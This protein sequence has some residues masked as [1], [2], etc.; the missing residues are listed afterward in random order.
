MAVGI[1]NAAKKRWESLV[2][3]A[4][5]PNGRP[6]LPAGARLGP[7]TI[8]GRA[9]TR[10]AALLQQGRGNNNMGLAG[11]FN[12]NTPTWAPPNAPRAPLNTKKFITILKSKVKAKPPAVPPVTP[13]T[14]Q[15][16][17]KLVTILK[18]KAVTGK[19]PVNTPEAAALLEA[20]TKKNVQNTTV[21]RLISILKSKIKPPTFTQSNNSHGVIKNEKGRVIGSVF[22]NQNGNP[23]FKVKGVFKT[24]HNGWSL[25][26]VG[27]T[28]YRLVYTAPEKAASS[29]NSKGSLIRILKNLA[30]RMPKVGA[31]PPKP[32]EVLNQFEEIVENERNRV[33]EEIAASKARGL[34]TR[35]QLLMREAQLANAA[36]KLKAAQENSTPNNVS[37]AAAAVAAAVPE[38]R[39]VITATITHFNNRQPV[40][41]APLNWGRV[42]GSPVPRAAQ[43]QRPRQA[44]AQQT[45][46]P[47]LAQ[48]AAAQVNAAEQAPR[49][50]AA[51]RNQRRNNAMNISPEFKKLMEQV[52]AAT[53]AA[54]AAPNNSAKFEALQQAIKE[55]KNHP[56]SSELTVR[57]LDI[58]ERM[59]GNK[60]K[61]PP[62]PK[63]KEAVAQ[64]TQ[65]LK[66]NITDLEKKEEK[67]EEKAK[68]T[69]LANL[70]LNQLLVYRRNAKN[71]KVNVNKQIRDRLRQLLSNIRTGPETNR[72]RKYNEILKYL[73]KNYVGRSDIATLLLD[74]VRRVGGHNSPRVAL[75]RLSNL[76]NNIG[77]F[78]NAKV[79]EAFEKQVKRAQAN[80][81]RRRG[82]YREN[83]GG[84]RGNRGEYYSRGNGGGYR[85]NGGGYYPPRGNG[86]GYPPARGNGGGY[87]PARG[88]G[89]VPLNAGINTLPNNQKRALEAVP[90]G[91]T[92]ANAV[93]NSVPGGQKAV[94]EAAE[95]L[96]EFPNAKQAME[97]KGISPTAIAAVKKIAGNKP[98]NA[99][100]IVGAV[101]TL[102]KKA[103]KTSSGVKRRRKPTGPRTAEI[104]RVLSRTLKKNLASLV[105][106]N[107][108]KTNNIKGT[109]KKYKKP[110]LK[111]LTKAQILRT[112]AANRARQSAKKQKNKS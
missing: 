2:R 5:G 7:T 3:F 108:T 65:N 33:A 82:E 72:A 36:N 20:A 111:I 104:N 105:A 50:R 4:P 18:S 89:G 11:L 22:L 41:G 99:I 73:P 9:A 83:R 88:N 106:H 90:G 30:A 94:I 23:G 53:T 76:R 95:A 79:V 59:Y 8:R 16:V 100:S 26:K 71:N 81:G 64:T 10:R 39:P 60:N 110:A 42:Q 34:P 48:N 97:V 25:N 84:Y 102:K 24:E 37:R 47:P 56:P 17:N 91:A 57:L 58:F 98:L 68:K 38:A 29:V 15:I 69:T 43:Q 87:P 107:I 27:N 75:Q 63:V 35:R 66:N 52:L 40:T 46:T 85:G 49:Q 21:T 1:S 96:N 14:K 31:P 44:A 55:L 62:T 74:E 103:R 112:K 28:E 78:A 70:S 6:N 109:L 54:R 45:Q 13:N 92:A 51:A 32:A 86:G 12:E 67:L 61:P 80:M 101:N 93:I 19:V 77:S